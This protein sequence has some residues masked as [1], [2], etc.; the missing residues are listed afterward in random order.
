MEGKNQRHEIERE[1]EKKKSEICEGN[2]EY[3]GIGRKRT[4]EGRE[5]R[6]EPVTHRKRESETQRL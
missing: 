3:N 2:Q 6:K 4:A 5:F 1:Y